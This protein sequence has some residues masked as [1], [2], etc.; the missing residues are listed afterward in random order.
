V[1]QPGQVVV[2]DNL[3]AHKQRTVREAIE[4]KGCQVVFLPPYSPEFNPIEQA[5]SKLKA[6]LRKSAARTREALHAAIDEAIACVTAADAQG[7]FGHSGYSSA[8]PI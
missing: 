7:W 2:W 1:L 3:A 6:L 5:W 4:A 8:Q